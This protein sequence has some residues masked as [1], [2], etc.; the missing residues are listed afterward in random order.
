MRQ[1]STDHINSCYDPCFQAGEAVMFITA[2]NRVGMGVVVRQYTDEYG[3]IRVEI[4]QSAADK[5][6]GITPT[7]D[8]VGRLA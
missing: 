3:D 5:A 2:L 7:A 8:R 6:P 1:M 4:R